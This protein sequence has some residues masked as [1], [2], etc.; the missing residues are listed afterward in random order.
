MFVLRS[1]QVSWITPARNLHVTKLV[2]HIV[3][4]GTIWFFAARLDDRSF[5]MKSTHHFALA[6]K[7]IDLPITVFI[8]ST[9]ILLMLRMLACLLAGLTEC[10]AI[11]PQ[12]FS[13]L[14]ITTICDKNAIFGMKSFL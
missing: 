4:S 9:L 14:K 5:C 11:L 10:A 6:I 3:T 13:I 8:R 12:P 1:V 7:S 2:R